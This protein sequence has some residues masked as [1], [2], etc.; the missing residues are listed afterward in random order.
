MMG[1][2]RARLLEDDDPF[3]HHPE[4]RGRIADPATSFFRTLSVRALVERHPR[5]ESWVHTDEQ[6][7]AIRAQA[8]QGHAGDLWIFAYGSLMWDPALRFAE[9]RRARADGHARR[10]ILFDDF[11]RG[12]Q[13]APGLMAALDAGDGCEGLAF[14]IRAEDVDVETEILFRREMIGPAY[15]PAFI[16]VRIAGREASALTF[17]ADHDFP[18]I[19]GDITRSD[20]IRYIAT[21]VGFLGTSRDYLANIVEHFAHLGIEDDHCTG[22]LREVEA[23]QPLHARAFEEH[24][25]HV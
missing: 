11:G 9:V 21:G 10:F 5:L 22:L 18:D 7:E 6:R 15:I 14:R 12:T 23:D 1:H 24:G 19:R 2:R 3:T 17:L 4:L 13:E 25:S 20:Q 8:L 16:P